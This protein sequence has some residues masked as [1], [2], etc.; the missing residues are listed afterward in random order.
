MKKDFK[1]KEV[2]QRNLLPLPNTARASLRYELSSTETTAVAS[3]FLLDLIEGGVLSKEFSYLVVDKCKIQRWRS[4]V[5]SQA[6]GSAE[7]LCTE[8]AVKGIFFDARKDKTKYHDKDVITGRFHPRIKNENH[9][10]VTSE[11]DGQYRYHYT[12]EEALAPHKPA[13]ME[14]KG[15]FDFMVKHG[16]DKTVELI[17]GD[18][19]N[20]NSGWKG[21]ALA[22]LERMLGRKVFWVICMIHCNELP[23]RHLM[24]NLDGKTNSKEGWTGPIGKF[25]LKVNEME[26][27]YSFD[28]IPWSEE[29]SVIYIPADIV[30][31]MSYDSSLFYQIGIAV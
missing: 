4:Q 12:P 29:D 31:N 16:W 11:P 27:N 22:W 10:T 9:V 14:A 23:L 5:M 1:K 24:S 17:G 28:P 6:S 8:D 15:L 2:G 25:L 20:S 19:T 30:T 21:S 3:S 13:Y 7:I 18:S 26:R